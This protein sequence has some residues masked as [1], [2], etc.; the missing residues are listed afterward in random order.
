MRP[1]RRPSRDT[2]RG[3]VLGLLKRGGWHSTMDVNDVD[4]GGSEG[5][6]RLRELRAMGYVIEKRRKVG[7]DQF[8]YRLAHDPF[9]GPGDTQ[10]ELFA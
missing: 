8:E 4:G 6:R 1:P 7:S 3:R 9:D 2:R 10:Q 5:C